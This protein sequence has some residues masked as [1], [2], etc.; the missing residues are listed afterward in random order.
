ML[1][2]ELYI[3]SFIKQVECNL[4]VI[5]RDPQPPP[6]KKKKK[7]KKNN[8]NKK[9]DKLIYKKNENP[10]VTTGCDKLW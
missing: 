9:I 7:K 6:P 1:M 3:I 4:N 8:N 5:R 2:H 10:A